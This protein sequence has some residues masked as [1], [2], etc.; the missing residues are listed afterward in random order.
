MSKFSHFSRRLKIFEESGNPQRQ[1]IPSQ[2]NI[3][4]QGPSLPPQHGYSHYDMP[5]LACLQDQ[6]QRY[7]ST[8]QQREPIE[9]FE[10]LKFEPDVPIDPKESQKEIEIDVREKPK[11][12]VHSSMKGKNQA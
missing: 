8:A 5:I 4:F 12:V 3:E 6:V 9:P 2:C 7:I 1:L 10:T 11:R